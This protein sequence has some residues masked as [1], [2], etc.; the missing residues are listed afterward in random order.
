MNA[1]ISSSTIPAVRIERRVSSAQFKNPFF[2]SG[3][4][5][6]LTMKRSDNR[7]P[8]STCYNDTIEDGQVPSEDVRLKTNG[9]RQNGGDLSLNK[10]EDI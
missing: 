10:T 5:T 2:N 6:V 1:K 4:V 7:K 9:Y 8:C 3:Y